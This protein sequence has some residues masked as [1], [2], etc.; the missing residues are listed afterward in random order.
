MQSMPEPREKRDDGH[1]SID[2]R[3]TDG[4]PEASHGPPVGVN[5]CSTQDQTRG[6]AVEPPRAEEFGE[7]EWIDPAPVRATSHEGRRTEAPTRRN[8]QGRPPPGK[9]TQN[10]GG[11]LFAGEFS[12]TDAGNAER[13]ARAHGRV[14]R[15]CADWQEWLI[16][17]E[18][19]W[20]RDVRGEVYE[21][22]LRTVRN[23]PGEVDVSDPQWTALTRHTLASQGRKGL[24]AM[25]SVAS[26]TCASLKITA[27]ELDANPW[28]LNVQNGTLD[29]RTFELR[30]HGSCDLI[31]KMCA[32]PYDA[33]ARSE[34]WERFIREAFEPHGGEAPAVIECLQRW[35]GYNL[36][37]DTSLDTIVFLYGAGGS[38][39]STFIEAIGAMMGGY[40]TAL[41][42]ESLMESTREGDT[43]SALAQTPGIRFVRVSEPDA[44]RRLASKK[45][46]SYSGGDVLRTRDVY[47]RSFEFTPAFKLTCA[48]NDRPRIDDDDS[49][50]ERRLY[51]FPFLAGTRERGGREDS[52]LR[53]SLKNTEESGAAILAWCVAGL[54]RLVADGMNKAALRVPPIVANATA[55]YRRENDPLAE[56][57]EDRAEFNASSRINRRDLRAAY[58][59]HARTSGET[60]ISD[61]EF[62]KRVRGRLVREHG[63]THN[64]DHSSCGMRSWVGI[65]LRQVASNN[66]D[67]HDPTL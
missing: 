35:S 47:A 4:A 29:L 48:M 2:R 26:K 38:G 17:R 5:G 1:A 18:G 53:T 46:K 36:T 32:A 49:G 37:G 66:P 33:A 39:K 3:G 60:V 50:L 62:A 55:E 12:L 9:P 10:S 14:L 56:F 23:I 44:K 61:K 20:Q 45:L 42:F 25:V 52:S 58:E 40:A 21:L 57:F 8:G 27:A 7:R 19:R 22:A 54:R 64:P 41:D 67:D 43:N 16:Y 11:S 63:A 31:T 13:L 30:P 28:L 24:E 51:C 6:A 59:Q 15:Y 65:R 34:A